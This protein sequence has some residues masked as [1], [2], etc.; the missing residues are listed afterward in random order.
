[1]SKKLTGNKTQKIPIGEI[2]ESYLLVN[3]DW[4]IKPSKRTEECHGTHEIDESEVWYK[5]QSLSVYFN[6][7]FAYYLDIKKLESKQESAI[8]QVLTVY[9]D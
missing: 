1:M 7:S 2:E 3:F 4:E 6:D 9:E 5:I 8:E